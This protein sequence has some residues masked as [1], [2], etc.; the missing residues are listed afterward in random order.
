MINSGLRVC[1]EQCQSKKN[2]LLQIHLH[3]TDSFWIDA[4][5]AA[6]DMKRKRNGG[7]HCGGTSPMTDDIT[8]YFC[9]MYH[10]F[11]FWWAYR[12][13]IGV[14]RFRC[15]DVRFAKYS[16]DG[17]WQRTRRL[18]PPSMAV[19]PKIAIRG[20]FPLILPRILSKSNTLPKSSAH[21][22]T[23]PICQSTLWE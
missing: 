3:K 17:Y 1:N 4:A 15:T 7:V 19:S 13:G 9:E 16:Y 11:A 20:N 12:V 2:Q 23:Y 6:T 14:G 21:T 18:K 10:F 5:N 22:Y 8:F